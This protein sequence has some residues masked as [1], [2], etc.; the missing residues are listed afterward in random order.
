MPQLGQNGRWR[1][2]VFDLSM[3]CYG[4]SIGTYTH[5]TQWCNFER[6]WTTFSDLAKIPTT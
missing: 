6:L 2:Y 4:L 3:C 5:S 1:C